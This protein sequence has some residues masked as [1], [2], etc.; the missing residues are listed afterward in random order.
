MAHAHPDLA[1]REAQWWA[2]WRAADYSWDGLA[3][4]SSQACRDIGINTLQDY[5]AAERDR[6]IDE[7]G[8]ARRWTR[9]HC[10]LVFADGSPSPKASWSD[11]QWRDLTDALSALMLDPCVL[12]AGVVAPIPA[13]THDDLWLNAP[14]A[15]LIKGLALS[16]AAWHLDTAWIDGPVT[17]EGT[18]DA[19]WADDAVLRMP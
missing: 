6:L 10:P 1:A 15:Y 7:P 2:A 17:A 4:K 8:T 13:V 5:W 12:F 11:A 18:V 14:Q 16:R 9:F 3:A 19:L